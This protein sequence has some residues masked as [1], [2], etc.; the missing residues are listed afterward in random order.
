M[1]PIGFLALFEP[2]SE[3]EAKDK[4]NDKKEE[5]PPETIK[6]N[7]NWSLCGTDSKGVTTSKKVSSSITKEQLSMM[8]EQLELRVVKTQPK[9]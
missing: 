8:M 4:E 1:Q 5:E 9:H 7:D 3:S 2:D 6:D